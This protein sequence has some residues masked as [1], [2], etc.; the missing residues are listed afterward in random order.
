MSYL[1]YNFFLFYNQ[2]ISED[3]G[4]LSLYILFISYYR[5]IKLIHSQSVSFSESYVS[6]IVSHGS[7]SF[8]DMFIYGIY[9]YTVITSASS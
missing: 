3:V 2:I 5:K 7:V 9:I 6:L 8:F 4:F 1:K